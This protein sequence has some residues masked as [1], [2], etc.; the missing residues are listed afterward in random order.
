MVDEFRP[1]VMK[2][3]EIFMLAKIDYESLDGEA[4]AGKVTPNI[5]Y[6]VTKLYKAPSRGQVKRGS[7]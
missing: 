7:L 4:P 6:G 2:Q 3:E 1:I 5:K